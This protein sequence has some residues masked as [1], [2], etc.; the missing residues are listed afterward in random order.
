[1]ATNNMFTTTI[2]SNTTTTANV[3]SS[4]IC[5]CNTIW[6]L[7]GPIPPCP[8]HAGATTILPIPTEWTLP[9][10]PAAAGTIGGTLSR[11]W[12]LDP[13][14]VDKIANK[15]V[16]KF[17]ALD[18]ETLERLAVRLMELATVKLRMLTAAVDKQVAEVAEPDKK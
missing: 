2:T 3:G 18:A 16:E 6:G 9:P 17:A 15:V 4:V 8:I 11:L 14:S 7:V 13:D 1:M 5:N 10:Q 12:S